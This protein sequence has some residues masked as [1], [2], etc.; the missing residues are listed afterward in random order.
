MMAGTVVSTASDDEVEAVETVIQGSQKAQYLARQKDSFMELGGGPQGWRPA[1]LEGIEHR[2]SPGDTLR[3]GKPQIIYHFAIPA[4]YNE[5]YPYSAI[6]VRKHNADPDNADNQMNIQQLNHDV[7]CQLCGWAPL[8]NHWPILNDKRRLVV[9]VGSE[10]VENFMG[11]GY[12]TK[13]VKKFRATKF[14]EAFDSWIEGA[15][16]ECE[17]HRGPSYKNKWGSMQAGWLPEEYFF[18]EKKLGKLEAKTL[19]TRKIV[20]IFKAAY[21]LKLTIPGVAAQMIGLPDAITVRKVVEAP[22]SP[23][24]VE[25][26]PSAPPAPVVPTGPKQFQR[27]RSHGSIVELEV[28]QGWVEA[29][30]NKESRLWVPKEGAT[31]K[32]AQPVAP[33]APAAPSSRTD[34]STITTGVYE[35]P[36]HTIYVVRPNRDGTR[37]YAKKLKQAPSERTTESGQHVNFD[38]EYDKGAIFKLK[39]EYRMSEERAKELTVLYGHCIVCGRTL[40]EAKSVERGIGPIC[41]KL[42]RGKAASEE[43][44]A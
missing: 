43:T 16:E 41:I 26:K 44:T 34:I 18:F 2:Y 7:Y 15:Q 11:A 19:T 6:I 29:N 36:D 25:Q 4:D 24:P 27:T 42:V 13:E 5:V 33:V 40:K 30:F 12:L 8:V 3:M 9:Q 35:T 1:P 22:K 14:R 21:E 37:H 23:T 28:A 39:P 38:F 31:P 10:C 32:S 17:S 20:N